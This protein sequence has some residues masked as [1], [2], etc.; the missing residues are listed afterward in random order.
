MGIKTNIIGR[1]LASHVVCIMKIHKKIS[2]RGAGKFIITPATMVI[3]HRF[4]PP[5]E[6]ET[7]CAVER[8]KT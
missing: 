3:W 8:K 2:I 6:R 7:L 4:K 1:L 5:L